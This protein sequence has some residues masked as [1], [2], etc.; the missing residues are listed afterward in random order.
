MP[1][2][3]AMLMPVLLLMDVMGLAVFRRDF[4]MAAAQSS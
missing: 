1:E 4:D 3:A 2:A